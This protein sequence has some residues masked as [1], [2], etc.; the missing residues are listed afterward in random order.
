MGKNMSENDVIVVCA[1]TNNIRKNSAK[2]GLSNIINIVRR[3]SHTS[4]MVMEV[5]HRHDLVDWSCVNK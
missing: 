1:G 5:L 2:E 4:I 3:N